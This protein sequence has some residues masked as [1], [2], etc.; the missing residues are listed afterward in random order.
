MTAAGDAAHGW[1]LLPVGG[2]AVYRGIDRGPF[3]PTILDDFIDQVAPLP[4]DRA[5]IWTMYPPGWRREAFQLFSQNALATSSCDLPLLRSVDAAW[6]VLS[7]IPCSAGEYE[8]VECCVFGTKDLGDPPPILAGIR[9]GYDLVFPEG[10]YYSAVK[11]GLHVN[12][13]P[14]LRQ[15]FGGHLNPFGLFNSA[16]QVSEFLRAFREYVPTE[17]GATFVATDLAQVGAS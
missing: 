12:P 6:K 3:E 7:S 9:M 8:V 1:L 13:H 16:D 2:L 4:A 10:D 5:G 14:V 11:N 17:A 15:R